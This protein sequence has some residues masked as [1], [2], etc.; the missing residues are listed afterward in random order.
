MDN[1]I[2][3]KHPSGDVAYWGRPCARGHLRHPVDVRCTSYDDLPKVIDPRIPA[4]CRT[5]TIR[6][7]WPPIRQV[8]HAQRT[9]PPMSPRPGPESLRSQQ[10][11]APAATTRA[12]KISYDDFVARKLSTHTLMADRVLPD[13]LAAA[14]GRMPDPEGA[15]RRQPC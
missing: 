3:P 11:V 2:L 5:P 15:S 9:T 4:G 13:L 7:G 10:S 12:K 14:A 1:G 8:I 6:H